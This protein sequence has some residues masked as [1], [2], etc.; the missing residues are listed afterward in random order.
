MK[1]LHKAAAVFSIAAL[2][3][4][5]LA[6]CGNSS[7]GSGVATSGDSNAKIKIGYVPSTMNNPFWQAILDA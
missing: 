1:V 5:G 3:V 4:A 2:A 7:D 6:G